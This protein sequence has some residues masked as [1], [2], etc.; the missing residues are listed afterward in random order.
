MQCRRN[1]NMKKIWSDF[2]CVHIV[3]GNTVILVLVFEAAH[4]FQGNIES[5]DII[6]QSVIHLLFAVVLRCFSLLTWKDPSR[7]WDLWWVAL[8]CFFLCQLPLRLIGEANYRNNVWKFKF[9]PFNERKYRFV[10]CMCTNTAFVDAITCLFRF[11]TEIGP[12]S[13]FPI[14]LLSY[15]KQVSKL[16]VSLIVWLFNYSIWQ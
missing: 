1:E 14:F 9:I 13:P 15:C 8:L 3:T 2:S 4:Y 16:S 5:D 6:R 12:F 10:M 7:E 11:C